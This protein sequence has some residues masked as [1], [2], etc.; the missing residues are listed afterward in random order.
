LWNRLK[1]DWG[2]PGPQ[3]HPSGQALSHN[4]RGRF[5]VGEHLVGLAEQP[6]EPPGDFHSPP[7]CRCRSISTASCK[8]PRHCF[9]HGEGLIHDAAE[10]SPH[11]CS[12]GR[13]RCRT[14]RGRIFWGSHKGKCGV[15]GMDYAWRRRLHA[16]HL[17]SRCGLS[18]LP[19]RMGRDPLA[20][21]N[22]HHS[23]CHLIESRWRDH[24]RAGI[25]V[26]GLLLLGK[27]EHALLR[28]FG[29]PAYI[30]DA[31]YLDLARDSVDHPCA[32]GASNCSSSVPVSTWCS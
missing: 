15:V 1:E 26:S 10:A 17:S 28:L 31:H 8:A 25:A 2:P 7:G 32:L 18:W 14:C 22:C 16:I 19:E 6:M 21:S 27:L 23:R 3:R 30:R 9:F 29:T 20:R 4:Q 12:S 24:V 11:H 13:I 5:A